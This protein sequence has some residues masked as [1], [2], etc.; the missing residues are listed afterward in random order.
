MNQSDT[1]TFKFNGETLKYRVSNSLD[2]DFFLVILNEHSTN[3]KIFKILG[4][5][6]TYG[7]CE[8]VLGRSIKDRSHIF[9]E[10]DSLSDLEKVVDA[11][12]QRIIK[13]STPKFQIGNLVM[14]VKREG[15]EGDYPCSYTDEM[16]QYEN[17]I[18]TINEVHEMSIPFMKKHIPRLK[19]EE[20]FFYSFVGVDWNWSSGMLRKIEIV[21]DAVKD[22]TAQYGVTLADIGKVNIDG[23]HS[24]VDTHTPITYDG[25]ISGPSLYPEKSEESEYKLTFKFNHLKF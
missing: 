13:I 10:L 15:D 6:D 7:F 19:Y 1:I 24:Y 16:L 8:E 17:R 11:L 3:D 2:K 20:P 21:K 18:F 5:D 22:I 12:Y 23:V 14:V 25:V 4:I 9:P